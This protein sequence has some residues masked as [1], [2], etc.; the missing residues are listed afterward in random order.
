MD[1]IYGLVILPLILMQSDSDPDGDKNPSLHE[2]SPLSHV[3]FCP[4]NAGSLVHSAM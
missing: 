1:R 4:H 3:E 2:H